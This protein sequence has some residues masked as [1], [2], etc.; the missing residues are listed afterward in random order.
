MKPVMQYE[1]AKIEKLKEYL[2]SNIKPKI[3]PLVEGKGC[4]VWDIEGRPYLDMCGQTLCLNLGQCFDVV[5][6]A[7]CFQARTLFFASSRFQSLIS[8]ELAQKI[9]DMAPPNLTHVNHKLSDGSDAVE[10][11]LKIGRKSSGRRAILAL[12]DAWHGES[13]E[14]LRLCSKY[15]GKKHD[16]LGGSRNVIFV[17]PPYC[18]RCPFR[19]SADTCGL[20]CAVALEKKVRKNKKK[21]AGFILDPIHFNAGLYYHPKRSKEYLQMAQEI[22]K[23]H[24][25]ALIFDEIQSFGGWLDGN[26]FAADFFSVSPNLLCL[27]KAFGAGLPIAAVLMEDRYKDVL[28]YNEAEFTYGGQAIACAAALASLEVVLQ[29]AE[30]EIPP[31]GQLLEQRL[32]EMAKRYPSI[33]DIRRVGLNVGVEFFSESICRQVYL[34]CLDRGVIFRRASSGTSLLIKPPLIIQD[35]EIHDAMDVLEA[36]LNSHLA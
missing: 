18:F 31:K 22:C 21:L 28:S 5:A 20:E 33:A 17:E 14:A 10:T 11:A 19:Q 3:P 26:L 36:V 32:R 7:V 34:S 8:L 30:F 35:E 4:W 25:I 16:Y 13:S 6:E 12:K 9:V 23:S 29:Q 2:S 1:R 24:N 27:G 15:S